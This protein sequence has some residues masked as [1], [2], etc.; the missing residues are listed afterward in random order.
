MVVFE[1]LFGAYYLALKCWLDMTLREEKTLESHKT[2][3][4]GDARF[5]SHGKVVVKDPGSKQTGT[6]T[7]LHSECW[8]MGKQMCF[9]MR[10][11]KEE[12]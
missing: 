12:D 1:C 3:K 6:E 10:S 8:T 11:G 9:G 5:S 7:A 4:S 2:L